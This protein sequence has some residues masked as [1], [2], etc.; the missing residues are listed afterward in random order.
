MVKISRC[1]QKTVGT[2]FCYTTGADL[3]STTTLCVC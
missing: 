1:N 3:A 2:C